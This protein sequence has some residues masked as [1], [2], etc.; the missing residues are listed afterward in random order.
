MQEQ[1][2]SY[3]SRSGQLIVLGA[4]GVALQCVGD[5][6]SQLIFATAT[7]RLPDRN[8]ISTSS[9][10]S[11]LPRS[12]YAERGFEAGDFFVRDRCPDFPKSHN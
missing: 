1:Q 7:R 10:M 5:N 4:E 6:S 11:E 3:P 9:S 2:C 12:K 8:I